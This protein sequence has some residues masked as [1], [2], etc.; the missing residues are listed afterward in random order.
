MNNRH[1]GSSGTVGISFGCIIIL[2]FVLFFI[3]FVVFRDLQFR[4]YCLNA[5]FSGLRLRVWG[6]RVVGFRVYDFRV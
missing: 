5:R 6:F 3:G 4:F 1:G 2:E